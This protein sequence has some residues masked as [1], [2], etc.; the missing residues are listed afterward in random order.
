MLR[1]FLLAVLYMSICADKST[2]KPTKNTGSGARSKS[3]KQEAEVSSDGVMCVLCLS[4]AS[5]KIT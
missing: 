3:V 2:E 4:F 1:V 5:S